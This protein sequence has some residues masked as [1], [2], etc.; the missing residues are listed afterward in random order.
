MRCTN[1]VDTT[2]Y[3]RQW[4]AQLMRDDGQKFVLQTVRLEFLRIQSRV[5]ESNRRP[6]GQVFGERQIKE[7]VEPCRSL[8]YQC[9]CA[10]DLP[11]DDYRRADARGCQ[12][13]LACADDICSRWMFFEVPKYAFFL[14]LGMYGS[15]TFD[16]P[17]VFNHVHDAGICQM[18]NPGTGKR[19]ECDFVIEGN[20]QNRTCFIQEP[21]RILTPLTFRG[22]LC[23]P[24]GHDLFQLAAAF[25]RGLFCTFPHRYIQNCRTKLKCVALGVLCCHGEKLN[26]DAIPNAGRQPQLDTALMP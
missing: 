11:A 3:R 19:P 9:D 16:R 8:G 25:P 1:L 26:V 4:C 7:A 14:A 10:N 17:I 13:R 21:L 18:W 24:L 12:L 2:Q 22:E 15:G 20:R 5:V 6:I 23:C